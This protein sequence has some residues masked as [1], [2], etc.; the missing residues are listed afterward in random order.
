MKKSNYILLFTL[1]LT[2]SLMQAQEEKESKF[3][4]IVYGGIGYGIVE[5][6]NEPNYN[7]NSNALEILVNYNINKKFGI[8]T[9]IGLNELSG[10]GF[11]SIGNFYHERTLLK[12]PLLFTMGSNVT[13]NLKL[14]TNF[15]FFGQNII[16]DEYR[17]LNETQKDI[18]KGWNFGAQFGFGFAFE[19]FDNYSI[20]I[21]YN[22]Q[23]DLSKFGSN[24]NAGINDK[25][26]FTNL[27][28][29]GILFMIDL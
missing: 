11:N 19:M 20:G 9:G 29:V 10:N 1:F 17:F 7:L 15:V 4:I 23:S 12:I 3:D 6:D 5:N 8:A 25:Q 26:K 18:Y 27:N 28:S 24:N 13:E 16:N 21:N 14:F 2:F 22:A